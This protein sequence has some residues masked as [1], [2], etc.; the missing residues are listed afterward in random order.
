MKLLLLTLTMLVS[1]ITF[2]AEKNISSGRFQIINIEKGSILLDTQTG[3][4]WRHNCFIEGTSVC[5]YNGWFL[6]DV[7]NINATEDEMTQHLAFKQR[8]FDNFSKAAKGEP[9]E[10]DF[11]KVK[12]PSAETQPKKKK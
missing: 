9:F 10:K 6:E 11:E 12:N 3:K 5:G 7:Q 2:G 1:T 8:L 4:I